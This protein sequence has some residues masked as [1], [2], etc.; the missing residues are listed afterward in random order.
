MA[1]GEKM[2]TIQML[3]TSR[4]HPLYRLEVSESDYQMLVDSG[5]VYDDIGDDAEVDALNH[6]GVN[7]AHIVDLLAKH[8]PKH[9]D[10]KVSIY[11]SEETRKKLIWFLGEVFPGVTYDAFIRRAIKA[12]VVGAVKHVFE[13]E[14]R[15]LDSNR[16]RL[17]CKCAAGSNKGIEYRVDCPRHGEWFKR[18]GEAAKQADA[19]TRTL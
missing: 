12:S 5:A 14:R 4:E 17:G 6:I 15:N 18:Y 1:Q 3:D 19:L 9:F 2:K 10:G 11:T 16:D 7:L 8:A 13:K